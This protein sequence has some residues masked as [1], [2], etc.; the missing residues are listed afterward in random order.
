MTTLSQGQPWRAWYKTARWQALKIAVHV[1]DAYMCQR[2]DVLCSGKYPADNSPVAD[3]IVPHRGDPKLFWDMD[4]IHT[5][6]KAYHDGEKQKQEQA[7]LHQ[8]G[9]WY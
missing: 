7:S 5:V 6:T 8:R 3:H 2:T 4:N 1:R 9:F